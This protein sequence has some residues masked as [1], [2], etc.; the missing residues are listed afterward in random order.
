MKIYLAGSGWH[1]IWMTRGIFD[2]YR[3]ESFWGISSEEAECISLYDG[4]LLDSGAFTFM[5]KGQ[6]GKDIDAYIKD[7]AGFIKKYNVQRFFELD[8]DSVIGYPRV[9]ELRKELEQA[10]GRSCIPVF[11]LSRGKD[12]F[13]QMCE[14]YK[15]VA[16]GGLLTDGIPTKQIARYLPWFIKQAHDRGCL[17]HGLGFTMLTELGRCHFDSVDSTAWL[18]GNRYGYVFRFNGHGFDKQSTPAGS[19]LKTNDVAWHRF[20]KYAETAL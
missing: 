7:Y 16:F 3:L 20:S 4:F 9:L 15:D 8:I 10:V 1:K 13:L 14:E 19:R 2:F 5:T 18:S 6:Q 17:I 12:A 11:H